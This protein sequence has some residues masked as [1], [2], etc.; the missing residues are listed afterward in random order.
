M[1]TYLTLVNELLRR[2][3]ETTLD[4]AGDGFATARN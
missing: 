2:L 3:N 4:T 1:S